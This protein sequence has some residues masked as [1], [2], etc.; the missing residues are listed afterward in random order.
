MGSGCC[1][2]NVL[3]FMTAMFV[4]SRTT[5]RRG[6]QQFVLQVQ[7][8][9]FLVSIMAVPMVS[10][11]LLLFG[12]SVMLATG[13]HICTLAYIGLKRRRSKKKKKSSTQSFNSILLY[14]SL[15]LPLSIERAPTHHIDEDH[16]AAEHPLYK[17]TNTEL[18]FITA[19]YFPSLCLFKTD[20]TVNHFIHVQ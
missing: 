9:F 12:S 10:R 2:F 17:K 20:K 14:H 19:I 18:Q 15:E 3:L 6:R 16:V 1:L 7:F 13:G 11:A 5:S 8:V 4:Y